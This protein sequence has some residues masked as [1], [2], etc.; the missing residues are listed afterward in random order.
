M[1]SP[2]LLTLGLGAAAALAL[3]VAARPRIRPDKPGL[4]ALALI[5]IAAAAGGTALLP[6]P[7]AGPALVALAALALVPAAAVA[8]AFGRVDMMAVVF[9]RD[10]GTDGATL[11]GMRNE[12]AAGVGAA[13]I[14]FVALAGLGGLWGWALPG[15]IAAAALVVAANPALHAWAGALRRRLRPPPAPP[16]LALPRL[17][18]DAARPDLL[19]L[20]LEGTDRRF[21]DRAVFG[22]CY[23]PVAALAPEALALTR[24]GQIAGTGWSLA[25]MVASQSGVPLLPRGFRIRHGTGRVRSFMPGVTF[26]GDVLAGKGYAGHYVVGCPLAFGGIGRMYADHGIPAQTGL[27]Q[28]RGMFPPDE[29]AAAHVDWLVDDEM[30]LDAARRIHAGLIRGPDPFALIV[31]TTG[32]HGQTGYLPR[33][34]C[35]DGRAR[36]TRDIRRAVAATARLSVALVRHAQA[37]AA[38][39][40]RPL[41]VVVLSDHLCHHDATPKSGQ[42]LERWNTVLMLGD[43]ATAGQTLD[44]AGSMVDVFPT[45]LEWLGWA[46]GPVAA[47]FGRSVLSAPPTLVEAHGIPAVDAMLEFDPALSRRLWDGPAPIASGRA[48]A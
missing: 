28:I 29:V 16:P 48:T 6:A 43:P 27:D 17:R 15:W 46:E 8:R 41:R 22:G 9:H 11:G 4:V 30:V 38:R 20:Y 10:F 19:V 44:R 12:V 36:R 34:A 1:T 13:V 42:G 35:P 5:V 39:A 31:E 3:A 26:L 23:D 32:P 24:I 33:S 40:G 21:S 18:P 25:G 7:G 47:G 37:E 2:A 45:L 14:A